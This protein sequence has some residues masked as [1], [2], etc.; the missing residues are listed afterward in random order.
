MKIQMQM[1]FLRILTKSNI[2][3]SDTLSI[4]QNVDISLNLLKLLCDKNV[5]Y[6]EPLNQLYL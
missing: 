5:V 2:D 6:S 1:A 3:L 4:S